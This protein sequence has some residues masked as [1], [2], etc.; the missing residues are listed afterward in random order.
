MPVRHSPLVTHQP[1]VA[2]SV[3]APQVVDVEHAS[4]LSQAKE[5]QSQSLQSPALGPPNEP[6]RQVSV[7]SHQPH[8]LASTQ[9]PQSRTSPQLLMLE[10]SLR[11]QSQSPHVPR[12]GPVLLPVRHSELEAHQP[13]VPRRVQSPHA[14]DVLHGSSM[15]SVPIQRQSVQAPSIGPSDVPVAQVAVSA[16]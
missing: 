9:S 14:A 8:P 2:R 7:E 1:Q 4:V 3:H 12:V 13:H 5:N 10:H 16:Q 6:A 11:T 15:H